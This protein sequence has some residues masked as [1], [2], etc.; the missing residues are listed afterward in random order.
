M[1]EPRLA[2]HMLIKALLRQM[3]AA[4]QSMMILKKGD[5]EAGGLILMVVEKGIPL[6]LLERILLENGQY[7]WGRVGPKEGTE[8]EAF[9]Q[10]LEKRQR[11]DPDIWLVELE[12]RQSEAL[13]VTLFS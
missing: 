3:D 4:G 9:R 6:F 13:A 8:P 2:T 7:G 1:S 5:Q 11:F 12:G 10:Y